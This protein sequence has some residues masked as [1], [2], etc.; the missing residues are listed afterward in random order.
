MNNRKIKQW[1]IWQ[2]SSRTSGLGGTLSTNSRVTPV[3]CTEDRTVFSNA[4][5]LAKHLQISETYVRYHL[6]KDGIVIWNHKKYIKLSEYK[7]HEVAV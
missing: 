6:N 4:S 1:P 7:K 3:V 2:G 5:T